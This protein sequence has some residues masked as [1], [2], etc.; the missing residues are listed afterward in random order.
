VNFQI[1][2][3]EVVEVT[4][5]SPFHFDVEIKASNVET[6]DKLVEVLVGLCKSFGL[7]EHNHD[8]ISNLYYEYV[9]IS[10]TNFTEDIC[11]AGLA[12]IKEH[13]HEVFSHLPEGDATELSMRVLSGCREKKFSL[14]LVMDK[15]YCESAVLTMA[16]VVFE[17]A[18]KF[19][20]ENMRWLLKHNDL[21]NS[22]IGK[23]RIRALMIKEMGQLIMNE[24]GNPKYIFSPDIMILH[25][26]KQFIQRIICYQPLVLVNFRDGLVGY[27]L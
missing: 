25:L 12:V 3:D 10:N 8:K 19:S 26:T 4:E 13:I 20:V 16:L 23:F 27:I 7:E 2:L 9:K 18:R 14:H 11:R 24:E 17:I 6:N 21:W 22:A 5:A 1:Q 15:I